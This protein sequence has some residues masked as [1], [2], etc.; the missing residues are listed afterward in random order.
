MSLI[1]ES[2]HLRISFQ[3]IK[4]ATENF[5]ICIGR[6]GY[7]PV[8]RGKLSLNG[9]PTIVAV[10]RLQTDYG[11][12]VKEFLT[13]IQMLSRYKHQNLVS[14]VGFCE[15][16]NERF[17]IYE[18]AEHGS[19]DKYLKLTK[20]RGPLTWKQRISICV[21][22]ARGLDHLHNH[23]AQNKRVIHRDIKSANIL[24]DHNWNAMI[25]DFGLSK[26]G[27]ANE[28]ET[29]LITNACGTH[30]YCDPAYI[31]T[32]IL[33]KESDVYSLGV[34]LFEVLCGRL[35]FVNVN[36]EERFLAQLA[37]RYYKEEKLNLIIDRDLKNHTNSDSMKVF[38]EIAF[39]C[40]QDDRDQRPS[41]GLVLRRLEKAL[42]LLEIEEAPELLE[43]EEALELKKLVET[44]QMQ[45]FEEVLEMQ[46]LEEALD[47][48]KLVETMQ[49][50]QFE[51][52]LE[53]QELE[54]ALG[55]HTLVETLQ[56]HEFEEALKLHKAWELQKLVETLEMETGE[57][58]IDCEV[59]K[60][61]YD[62]PDTPLS[63]IPREKVYS[64]LSNG[65][66]VDEGNVFQDK[67][68]IE[69]SQ[70]MN[71]STSN[72]NWDNRL[73][74]DYK[75]FIYYSNIEMMKKPQRDVSFPTKEEAYSILSRGLLIK[76]THQL[77]MWFWITKIDGKKCFILPPTLLS[78]DEELVKHNRTTSKHSRI[79]NVLHLLPSRVVG[80]RFEVPH[81]LLSAN[82]TYGCYLVYKM[83]QDCFS[84]NTI[85]VMMKLDNEAFR[86]TYLSIPQIPVIGPDGVCGSPSPMN[87]LKTIQLPRKREDGWLEMNLGNKSDIQWM[88][89]QQDE[90]FDH[91]WRRESTLK[92]CLLS[93]ISYKESG[94]LLD[95]RADN[96]SHDSFTLDPL[97]FSNITIYM[98]PSDYKPHL[99][100]TTFP[101]D[102]TPGLIV[103]GIEFRPV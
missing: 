7:G 95:N 59:I 63:Y 80:M 6:G 27:R 86:F 26:I 75:Q 44:L 85:T 13:E 69:K 28:N 91:F 14:L 32:G 52:V 18:Y 33:T 36:S 89:M 83:P 64:H 100:L 25:A 67:D 34:V 60:A 23:V 78:C 9:E 68:E 71:R 88:N 87:K 101:L 46:E 2:E 37:Q 56:R 54:E 24:L 1:K 58:R 70:L 98:R 5:T 29:Y 38:S 74:S 73:P 16:G 62:M 8:Y 84:T 55:L 22:A 40:L 72:I 47:L 82:T 102:M 20:T 21:D 53:M 3:D 97:C 49:M 94:N 19:L 43:L 31:H 96:V 92:S 76:V 4:E 50:Q 17:L 11:Q 99:G 61:I 90:Q 79:K 39:Q 77:N 57:S 30:G 41:M 10:K 45:Q 103:Q 48:K 42:K 66:L 12:G 51:E 35:C 93:C 15:E 65:I 81:G